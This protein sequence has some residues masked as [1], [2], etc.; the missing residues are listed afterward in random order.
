MHIQLNQWSIADAAEIMN[1]TG[2]DHQYV[3]RA[4]LDNPPRST[5]VMFSSEEV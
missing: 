5:R 3:T 2:F 4:F 1:L